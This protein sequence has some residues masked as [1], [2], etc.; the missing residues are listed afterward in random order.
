MVC[1]TVHDSL[2]HHVFQRREPLEDQIS[3][4]QFIYLH[5]PT[6]SPRKYRNTEQSFHY[7]C[8]LD[9]SLRYRDSFLCIVYGSHLWR[10]DIL[11]PLNSL[12]F[13]FS[14][15]LSHMYFSFPL[16][17]RDPFSKVL[18]I[19]SV[20]LPNC[21]HK[22]F[23]SWWQRRTVVWSPSPRG[24]TIV[25]FYRQDLL[26]NVGSTTYS[27]SLK[28]TPGSP[29]SRVR[30]TDLLVFLEVLSTHSTQRPTV[31]RLPPFGFLS[32]S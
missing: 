26:L 15:L 22:T 32:R 18:E 13:S 4:L 21:L 9:G 20:D 3:S 12:S 11:P 24:R 8:I 31:V 29:L 1:G 19:L 28:G 14:V 5:N 6:T 30:V 27:L 2:C 23:T 25:S 16:T 10:S 17:L 7:S